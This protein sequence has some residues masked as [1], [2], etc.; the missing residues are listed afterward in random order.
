[1]D[2]FYASVE[3]RDYPELKGKPV[4]VGGKRDRGVIAAASYEAR[5]FGVKSAMPS[6]VALRKCPHLIFQ[7]PRMDVYKAVSYEIRSIFYEYTDLVEPLSLDEAFLDV[8]EDKL[9]I[10]SASIIANQI[11]EKIKNRVD[12]T[13]SAGISYNKFLAKTAS[14]VNKP[15]GFFLIRPEDSMSFLED[16]DIKRFFGIGKATTEKMHK[17]GIFKGRD[18]K[19]YDISQMI[20]FFGKPGA[21]FYD[22]VR[23][24]DNRL[25]I[26]DRIRK[27]VGVERTYS[28]DIISI[29]DMKDA[30]RQLSFEL[31]SRL[32]KEGRSGRTI[33]IKLR[34]HDFEQFTRSKTLEDDIIDVDEI[35]ILCMSI[36]H[37]F[38]PAKGIRLLGI[39]ISNLRGNDDIFIQLK[40][41][42]PE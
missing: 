34:Y 16:L 22:I 41:D 7:P 3:Q 37:D 26:P 42:F 8:T 36:L 33:T 11:R 18:L 9:G 12:L 27:S 39:S 14:D 6:V 17:L 2:A 25:V 24:I 19:R 32:E 30:F 21:F 10:G 20:H 35:F 4:V 40:L 1:M 29:E 31:Y 23:G 5:V 38:V 15:N 13:S 28:Q